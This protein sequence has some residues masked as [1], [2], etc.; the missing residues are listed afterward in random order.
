[1]NCQSDTLDAFV[2]AGLRGGPKTA[3]QV[4]L[5]LPR[6]VLEYFHWSEAKQQHL[7]NALGRLRT[8]KYIVTGS[9][10]YLALTVCGAALL[11]ASHLRAPDFRVCRRQAALRAQACSP[12]PRPRSPTSSARRTAADS[13]AAAAAS[14]AKMCKAPRRT[15]P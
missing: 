7:A 14:A 15:P 8:Q 3:S 13:A 12:P 9:K 4:A 6:R 10:R 2:L 11:Q 1:M 5:A